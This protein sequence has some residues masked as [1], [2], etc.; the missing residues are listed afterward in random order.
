MSCE[1][2]IDVTI[3]IVVAANR[4][5]EARKADPG[6]EGHVSAMADLL[7]RLHEPGALDALVKCQPVDKN[8]LSIIV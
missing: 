2:Q 8:T 1:N 3:S 6:S 5:V 7:D 4:L